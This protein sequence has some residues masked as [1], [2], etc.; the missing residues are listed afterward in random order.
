MLNWTLEPETDALPIVSPL[1]DEVT[2]GDDMVSLVASRLE[3][4]IEN[5]L[6]SPGCLT[7][8]SGAV[9]LVSLCIM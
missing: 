4:S 9:T 1:G 8:T 7:N 2:V 3:K 5:C 6:V